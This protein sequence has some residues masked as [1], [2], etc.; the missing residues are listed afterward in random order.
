M[1]YSALCALCSSTH[2][3][4]IGIYMNEESIETDNAIDKNP[5]GRPF[6]SKFDLGPNGT[7]SRTNVIV[8]KKL[9]AQV[10]AIATL[11]SVHTKYIL[12]EALEVYLANYK[13]LNA[14]KFVD[15]KKLLRG[16]RK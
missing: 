4:R 6:G 11:N 2:T 15:V 13:V 14:D 8:N 9:Y 3:N 16:K 12:A 10:K 1:F 5:V 7:E